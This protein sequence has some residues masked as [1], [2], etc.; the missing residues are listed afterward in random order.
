[1][2]WAALVSWG[3]ILGA[4]ILPVWIVWRLPSYFLSVPIG[5]L[6]V[7][8]WL[9]VDGLLLSSLDPEYD[10]IGPGLWL[11]LGWSVGLAYCCILIG[12][13]EILPSG[14]QSRSARKIMECGKGG[15]S[16]QIHSVLGL[17]AWGGISVLCIC[18]PFIDRALYGVY[19]WLFN[20]SAFGPTLLLS[21]TMVFINLLRF[22]KR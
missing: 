15:N 7:W 4:L 16:G 13:Y 2:D 11:V 21:V 19:D 1:M 22:L 20:L 10:S 8:G 9:M 6:I 17:T 3:C 12:L 5:T 18:Y 14:R